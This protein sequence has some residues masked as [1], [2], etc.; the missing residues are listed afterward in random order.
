M[1]LND[2]VDYD[3]LI[4]HVKTKIFEYE[5][6]KLYTL[7]PVSYF[8]LGRTNSLFTRPGDIADRGVRE[9]IKELDRLP[10]ILS[11]AKENLS[12]PA[13]VWTQNAIYRSNIVLVMIDAVKGFTKQDKTII[14]EVIFKTKGLIIIVN[15]WDLIDKNNESMQNFIDEMRY[16]FK[17]ID[18]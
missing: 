3:L 8:V 7:H 6:I 11:N 4:S 17:S 16:Q 9:A 5:T 12:N 18:N 15:K 10:E 2:Q 14:D 13:R 1:S